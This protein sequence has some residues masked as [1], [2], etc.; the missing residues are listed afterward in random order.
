MFQ[1][2]A[3]IAQLQQ[4]HI[5]ISNA[6]HA[7]QQV[8][9]FPCTL[10]MH[11]AIVRGSEARSLDSLLQLLIKRMHESE[12]AQYGQA[13]YTSDRF[14]FD[15]A[16]FDHS[17]LGAVVS[18]PETYELLYCNPAMRKRSG[19]PLDTPLEGMKC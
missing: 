9:G 3:H 10:Y 18:D 4:A 16:A 1:K 5:Q 2:S 11:Y 8:D 7:I 15:R 13:L 6:I 17:A 19:I 14:I 12:E